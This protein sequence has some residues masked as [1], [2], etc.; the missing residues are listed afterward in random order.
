MRDTNKSYPGMDG[1][2]PAGLMCCMNAKTG[3]ADPDTPLGQIRE[4]IHR[5]G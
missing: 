3:P 5:Y 1:H 2:D 4:E